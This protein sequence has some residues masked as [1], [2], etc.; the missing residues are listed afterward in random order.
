[1]RRIAAAAAALASVCAFAQE[2]S[3]RW[4]LQVEND[5][6]FATDRWYTSG[7]RLARVGSDGAE[8]G[9]LQEVYTPEAKRWRSGV[10]DRAPSARLL[11]YHARHRR[12]EHE[13][14]TLE[15]ALGVR[16]PAALGEKAT[17]AIHEIVPAPEVDWSREESNRFDAQL[18]AVRSHRIGPWM[19]HGGAVLGNE[20]AFGHVGFEWRH[21]DGASAPLRFAATPP[22]GAGA[23]AWDFFAGVSVRAVARN[24]MLRRNYDPAGPEISLRRGVGRF[25]VGVATAQPWGSATFALVHETREF[26]EQRATHG[27]GV[28]AVHV[29][30]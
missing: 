28:L 23:S 8:W 26:A 6:V 10:D 19:I 24:S 13:F 12:A 2:N 7:V 27:F 4:Y 15:I 22:P 21:G 30:F 9:L 3:P 1:M 14:D 25:A 17:D 16:G 18:A 29:A 11:A 20:L 5:V